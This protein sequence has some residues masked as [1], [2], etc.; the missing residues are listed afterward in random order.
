MI[1]EP[2]D[3]EIDT[4]DRL[5]PMAA[6]LHALLSELRG[7]READAKQRMRGEAP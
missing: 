3:E 5:V 6:E 2:T 7:L 1:C 4:F